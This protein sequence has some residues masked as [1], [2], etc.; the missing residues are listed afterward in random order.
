M[1]CGRVERALT[2]IKTRALLSATV[3]EPTLTKLG[4]GVRDK[5]H[6]ISRDVEKDPG[7]KSGSHPLGSTFCKSPYVS[8][9]RIT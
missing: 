3:R 9:Q 8:Y 5:R 1:A 2:L 7:V 6:L 4:D